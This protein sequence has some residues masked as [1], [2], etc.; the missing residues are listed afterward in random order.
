MYSTGVLLLATLNLWVEIYI[1]KSPSS[2]Q[3]QNTITFTSFPL[4]NLQK[5]ELISSKA[6]E[7][8]DWNPAKD[9]H[10]SKNN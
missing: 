6:E 9:D 7:G 5:K 2:V 4:K 1:P 8:F 3:H 10:I